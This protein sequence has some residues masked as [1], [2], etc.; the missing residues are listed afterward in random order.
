MFGKALIAVDL[1]SMSPLLDCAPDLRTWGIGHLVLVH[2]LRVGYAQGPGPGDEP[3]YRKALEEIGERLRTAGFAVDVRVGLTGDVG[4]ALAT[5]ASELPV[6]LL[7]VGSRSRHIAQKIFLGSVARKV[8]RRTRTPVLLHWIEPAEG[9]EPL[10]CELTC[11]ETLRHVLLATDLTLGS[12]AAQDTAVA[13]AARGA[14][15]DCLHVAEPLELDRFP[16]W[17][18]MA[19]AALL[20]LNQRIVAAGGTG[21]VLVSRGNPVERILEIASQLDGSLVVVGKRGR[22]FPE[23][24]TIGSTARNLSKQSRRPVLMVPGA[25]A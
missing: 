9:S 14:R 16:D 23:Q 4:G 19:R 11:A 17:E 21:E 18:L 12:H 24:V 5:L 25:Q 15:V 8:L 13:L 1:D 20:D 6:D 22:H 3:R 10:R 7:V 2:F